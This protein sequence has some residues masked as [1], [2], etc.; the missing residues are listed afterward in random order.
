[1]QDDPQ[2]ASY[3]T[4]LP[5]P[6]GSGNGVQ[7]SW[8][9]QGGC[10]D[11]M[12]PPRLQDCCRQSR[13]PSQRV[14][15]QHGGLLNH[16]LEE[17]THLISPEAVVQRA[18]GLIRSP[19]SEQVKAVDP[20]TKFGE[21]RSRAAPVAAGRS[22]TMQQQKCMPFLRASH[23]PMAAVPPP[24]PDLLVTPIGS[25]VN[26]SDHRPEFSGRPLSRRSRCSQAGVR[27][28]STGIPPR[29]GSVGSACEA[30][31]KPSLWAAAMA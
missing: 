27:I 18:S 11:C 3:P 24:I 17:G 6:H 28:L 26:S 29:Q 23:T 2:Q 13:Q 14:S 9:R 31:A 20:P 25:L 5:S 16:L 12:H 21:A 10:H 1:M 19:E 7:Q 30:S 8:V 22:E 15:D 4:T